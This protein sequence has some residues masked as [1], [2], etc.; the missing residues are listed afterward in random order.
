MFM[1][2]KNQYSEN[3]LTTQSIDSTQSLSNYQ[4]YF[5]QN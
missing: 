3:E 5:P 1:D 4:W 2:G